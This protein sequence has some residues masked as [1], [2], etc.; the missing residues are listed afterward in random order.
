MSGTRPSTRERDLFG[1][2]PPEGYEDWS[3]RKGEPRTLAL[4][5]MIF[6]MAAS[7]WMFSRLSIAP[8]VSPSVSRPAAREMLVFVMVGACVLYPMLR[9]AQ[10]IPLPS[11][12]GAGL[13]DALVL[14]IPMQAVL[15]PNRLV[16]LGGW[17]GGVILAL[18]VFGAAW[19]LIVVGVC[20][21]TLAGAGVSG[22]PVLVRVIGSLVIVALALGVPLVE[23]VTRIGAG[24]DARGAHL[25]W[26]LSPITGVVELTRDRRALG[27]VAEVHAAHIEIIA[28]VAC[29]GLA[30]ILV[31]AAIERAVP[32][33]DR[34][35][36]PYA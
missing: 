35:M 36:S 26:M 27:V 11:V 2:E 3:H 34:R 13:R 32:L 29:V 9:L 23:L 5:W 20:S 30:M 21:I 1:N 15:W 16:V 8:S 19:V 7:A 24:V 33:A 31:G 6:L 10:A 18:A 14:V 4:L 28:S 12:T 17:N 22:R 25:G